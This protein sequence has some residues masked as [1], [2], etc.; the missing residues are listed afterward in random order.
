ML[1]AS[2]NSY[3]LSTLEN[4]PTPSSN[5]DF[6]HSIHR[7]SNHMHIIFSY[8]ILC[9]SVC[10]SYLRLLTLFGPVSLSLFCSLSLFPP[11]SSVS[12]FRR[13]QGTGLGLPQ[14]AGAPSAHPGPAPAAA[15]AASYSPRPGR[16]R[17]RCRGKG[18]S[19]AGGNGVWGFPGRRG[20]PIQRGSA[21]PGAGSLR[22]RRGG[23]GRARLSGTP[24]ARLL[25]RIPAPPRGLPRSLLGTG[26]GRLR[27]AQEEH[28]MFGD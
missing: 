28:P 26:G 17:R 22:G 23:D 15:A 6:P 7:N 9:V 21:G 5:T 12:S 14:P 2:N 25:L 20:R 4:S 10:F 1:P 11:A 24:G 3:L 19:A 27:A 8:S 13:P 16:P 18:G